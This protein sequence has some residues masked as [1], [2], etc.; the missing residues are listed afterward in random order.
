MRYDVGAS[1][2]TVSRQ[3]KKLK[4]AGLLTSERRGTCVYY[5]V[6]PSVLAAMGQLLTTA[7]GAWEARPPSTDDGE[8]AGETEQ[9]GGEDGQRE[10]YAGAEVAA[11]ADVDAVA[12]QDM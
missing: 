10:D 7:A 6:E 5:R 9:C 1:Q 4:G 12:I 2:P 8:P 11:P 3:L